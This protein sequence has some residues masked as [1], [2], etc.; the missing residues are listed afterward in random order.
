[1]HAAATVAAA[2]AVAMTAATAA[3][4]T[5]AAVAAMTAGAV[6]TLT[7]AVHTIHRG[8]PETLAYP[9]TV[10]AAAVRW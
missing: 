4:V 1:M 10:P 8:L 5:V 3:V 9:G 2:V 6:V 7:S